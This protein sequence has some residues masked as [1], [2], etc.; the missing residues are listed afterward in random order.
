MPSYLDPDCQLTLREALR[1]FDE[2]NSEALYHR[3][4][5]RDSQAF[6]RCHDTAHVVFACDISMS[7]EGMVKIWTAFGT[8][9]GFWKHI[10]AYSRKETTEIVREMSVGS[11]VATFFVSLVTMP[12]VMV[13]CA[14]MTKKWPWAEH[15]EYLDRKLADI[16]REFNIRP[17]AVG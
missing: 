3:E 1:E 5:S 7:N 8:T 2:S 14:A 17:I 15:E 13:R 4:M 6:F 12:R 10:R 16:R 9:L 11:I